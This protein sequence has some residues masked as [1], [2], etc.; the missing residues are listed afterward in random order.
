[1][2][3]TLIIGLLMVVLAA[4]G[5]AEDSSI[6]PKKLI[7]S[8]EGFLGAS[9][10]VELS[11]DETVTYFHNPHTFTADSRTKR[12]RIRVP[13]ER[14]RI[15]RQRLDAAKVW[16]WRR[17]YRDR[18]VAD[19]TVWHLEVAYADRKIICDGD[20]AYPPEKQFEEF[21]SAVQELVGGKRF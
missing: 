20:N 9:Y 13:A 19:G 8:I 21:R 10:K 11:T 15:F 3:P 14:W 6:I 2:K 5:Q 16:S 4:A 17:E 7:V 1:M 12:S 18:S